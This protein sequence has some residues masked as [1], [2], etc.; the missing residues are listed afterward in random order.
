[1]GIKILYWGIINSMNIQRTLQ[2]PL[3][4][5]AKKMIHKAKLQSSTKK[6]IRYEVHCVNESKINFYY[7]KN[8]VFTLSMISSDNNRFHSFDWLVWEL[9]EKML[10][11]ASKQAL[12]EE[13]SKNNP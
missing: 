3:E 6:F 7:N 13:L 10:S 12:K 9:E 1:M 5:I 4:K 11:Y 8:F 2:K